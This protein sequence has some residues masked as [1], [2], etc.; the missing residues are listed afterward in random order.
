MPWLA[1]LRVLWVSLMLA[2]ALLAVFRMPHGVLFYATVAATEAGY[3]L[4]LLTLPAFVGGLATPRD[5]ALSA[6]G[7]ATLVLLLSPLARVGAVARELPRQLH[8]AFGVRPPVVTAMDAGEPVAPYRALALLSLTDPDVPVETLVYA[9]PDGSSPLE[10]D[11]YGGRVAPHPRT[12]IVI[13]HGGSWR[14]GNSEQLTSM[15][16]R[17]AA[18]G[19][20]VAAINYRLA[21]VH[22]FPAA[23]DDLRSAVD[24]LRGR[25]E[26]LSIDADSVVLYGRSAGGHLVLLA[27]YRWGAPFVR[28]VVALY[29]PTD[30]RY[31]WEHPSNPRILDTPGTLRA[32]MG[33]APDDSPA[34]GARYDDASPYL[35]AGPAAPPTLLIHGGRDELVRPVHSARLAERLA[36]LGVPHHLLSLPWATHGCEA[37]PAGPSG[38]LIEY[39]VRAFLRAV[40][41]R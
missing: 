41:R 32:F 18:A 17:L 5:I 27:A 37:N 31:S 9:T 19:Y 26:E 8:D 23:Y 24:H 25:S 10:L 6:V 11:F 36:A 34:M 4:A 1:A 40:R 22:P 28:G 30:L 12:L 3:L 35:A 33:G 21:P 39:A 13:V 14:N 16:K 20:A 2:W 15:A 29:P 7:A 38:Q